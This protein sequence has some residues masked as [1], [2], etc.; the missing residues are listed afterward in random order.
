MSDGVR[1]Y[2][3]TYRAT[4]PKKR[5]G[6]NPVRAEAKFADAFLSREYVLFIHTELLCCIPGCRK[7]PECAHVGPHTRK[8]GG[9]WYEI[10][11]LCPEHHREQEGQTERMNRKYGVDLVD[12]AAATALRWKQHSNQDVG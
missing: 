12:I 7:V 5:L 1:A 10:A 4:R 8:M 9:K 2:P 3:K 6:K 11:P